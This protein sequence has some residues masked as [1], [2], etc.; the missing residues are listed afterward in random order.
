MEF[1]RR[2]QTEAW[3]GAAFVATVED[4]MLAK[5]ERAKLGG[6]ARQIEDVSRLIEYNRDRLDRPHLERWIDESDIRAQ[7]NAAQPRA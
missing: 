7:W 5:L 3:G 2:Q 1:E 4:L 6:S